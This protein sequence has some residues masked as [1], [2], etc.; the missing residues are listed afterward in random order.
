MK[1]M[2][3]LRFGLV[4]FME[5]KWD[6]SGTPLSRVVTVSAPKSKLGCV[7]KDAQAQPMQGEPTGQGTRA[8]IVTHRDTLSTLEDDALE[9]EACLA[10]AAACAA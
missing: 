7:L 5:G 2:S 8:C 6:S 3:P 9:E 10:A 1:S 4:R